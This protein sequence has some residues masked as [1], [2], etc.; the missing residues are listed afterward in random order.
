MVT[1][2]NYCL[3]LW[4]LVSGRKEGKFQYILYIQMR[5]GGERGV[6][7]V[8]VKRFLEEKVK[9]QAATGN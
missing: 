8:Y 5:G 4:F 7:R 9:R 1:L 3:E 2:Q 6:S